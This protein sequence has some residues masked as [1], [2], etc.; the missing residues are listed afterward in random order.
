[1][2]IWL[3]W[4]FYSDGICKLVG[5]F[6]RKAISGH[7]QCHICLALWPGETR[8]MSNVQGAAPAISGKKVTG[9]THFCPYERKRKETVIQNSVQLALPVYPWPLHSLPPLHTE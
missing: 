5:K 3:I 1:M 9:K 6:G 7:L 2:I 8:R 4:G